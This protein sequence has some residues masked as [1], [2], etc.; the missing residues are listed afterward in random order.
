MRQN[1]IYAIRTHK[2]KVTTDSNHTFNIASNLMDQD[3]SADKPNQKWTGDISY[4]WTQEGWLYLA[5]IIDLYSRRV[6][7]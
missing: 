7:G 3:F 6:V 2:Y 1:N 4:L 5:G